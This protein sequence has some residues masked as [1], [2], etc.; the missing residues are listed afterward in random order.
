[1]PLDDIDFERVKEFIDIVIEYRAQRIIESLNRGPDME[2][3][4]IKAEAADEII[5]QI[6][7]VLIPEGKQDAF[8][9]RYEKK[10]AGLYRAI[11]YNRKEQ[12]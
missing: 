7:M 6:V 3:V 10:Q 4:I 5:M 8:N 9:E 1:M 11:F 2:E 12:E